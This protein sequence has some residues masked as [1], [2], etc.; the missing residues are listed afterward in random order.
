M[1]RQMVG[2]Q[3]GMLLIVW[4]LEMVRVVIVLGFIVSDVALSGAP[5][6]VVKR[7]PNSLPRRPSRHI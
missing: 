4:P 2:G 1:P 6:E 5:N 7:Y 3:V